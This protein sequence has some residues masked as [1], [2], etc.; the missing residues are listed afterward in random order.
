MSEKDLSIDGELM[1]AAMPAD[2]SKA[3]AIL[4]RRQLRPEPPKVE[5]TDEGN[6]AMCGEDGAL[7]QL[8]AMASLGLHNAH[9]LSLVLHQMTH[10]NPSAYNRRDNSHVNSAL[11]MFEELEPEGGNQTMLAAQMVALHTAAMDCFRRAAVPNQ[12]FEG[13]DLNLKFGVKLSAAYARHVE[14][15]SKL[16]RNG[17]QNVNVRHV[18]V[19]EGGQAVVGN[20]KAN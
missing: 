8:R 19:H 12:T 1:A 9:A 7:S 13:R 18:H 16:K 2:A 17:Q 14:A 10:L 15:M 4:D 3:Q 5:L 20:V 6:I 11:A